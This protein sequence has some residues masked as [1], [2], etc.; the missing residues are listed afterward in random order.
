MKLPSRFTEASF[1]RYEKLI[2]DVVTR[3]PDLT[4]VD[5]SPMSPITVSCRF[6]DAM[7]SL[8]EHRW[9]TYVNMEKF[10][11]VWEN[12]VVSDRG[13]TLLIG[14]KE[15]LTNPNTAFSPPM[16]VPN[17]TSFV[18]DEP[19][20][21]TAFAVLLSRNL[22]APVTFKTTITEQLF[23]SLETTHNIGIVKNPDGSFTMV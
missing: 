23:F 18:V 7:R 15:A 16:V 21:L 17:G 8:A 1:R 10:L 6:R 9:T 20:V 3:F 2:A 14:S 12:I 11:Q 4:T 22:I 13:T 19:E 5:P